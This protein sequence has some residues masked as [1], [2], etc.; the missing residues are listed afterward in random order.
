MYIHTNMPKSPVH[1]TL[2]SLPC[3]CAT[4]RRASRAVT[5]MYALIMRESGLEATQFTLLQVLHRAGPLTQGSLGEMLAMDS[6]T[7]SRTLR[8]LESTG[9]IASTAGSDRRRRYWQLT[10]AGTS[11]LKRVEPLWRQAQAQLHRALGDG[12]WESLMR[13]ADRASEAA[14]SL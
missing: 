3:A 1:V 14:L 4:L 7:L 12:G 13:A 6:T 8:P 10:P 2:P 5:Q 9:W 11:K